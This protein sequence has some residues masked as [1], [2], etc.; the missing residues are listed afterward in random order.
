MGRENGNGSLPCRPD[1][2][3]ASHDGRSV[4]SAVS[5]RRHDLRPGPAGRRGTAGRQN[6]STT[7]PPATG[8]AIR[9]APPSGSHEIPPSAPAPNA[10]V[11]AQEDGDN[12]AR[13]QTDR[14][15][16][17][18]DDPSHP[19]KSRSQIREAGGGQR[20]RTVRDPVHRK[21]S[22]ALALFGSHRKIRLREH[23]PRRA[24]RASVAK[25]HLQ[26][27]GERA[28]SFRR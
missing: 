22:D 7:A 27:D 25:L 10:P 14:S 4:V 24:G 18:A 6:P 1:Q 11:F 23:V 26:N 17:S 13:G 12:G 2:E 16:F 5:E 3:T 19:I 8:G 9:L 21:P 20:I 28:S 15:R